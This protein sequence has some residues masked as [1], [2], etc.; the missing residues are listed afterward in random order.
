MRNERC[1]AALVT[2]SLRES[3]SAF[4]AVFA[5][6]DLRRLQLAGAGSVIG[7][8][9]YGIALAVYAYREGGAAAVG[10]LGVVRLLPSALGAPF[11]SQLADRF[12]RQR[13]MLVS[14]LVRLA[15]MG[16]IAAA[17]GLDAPVAVVFGL[18]ALSGLAGTAFRPAQAALLPTLA[19]TPREL[20]AANVAASTI[21]SLGS[22]VGPAL[23]GLLLVVASPAW[24][25]G[26]NALTFVWS[27]LLVAGVRGEGAG[28]RPRRARGSALDEATAG[29]RAIG[30]EPRVRVLVAL[31]GAQTF[32]DGARPVLVV[33]AAFSMLEI[34]ESGVGFLNSALGVGGLLGAVLSVGLVGRA[35][36]GTDFA[37]GL[38]LW[39]G[40]LALVGVWPE[41]AAA[42]FFLAVLGIGNTLVDVAGYTLL[43][44]AAP[45]EVLARV[46]GALDSLLLGTA[47]LG[48]LVAP[49]A[50]ELVGI[51]AAVVGLGGLLPLLAVLAWARLR[52]LDAAG[53]PADVDLLRAVPMLAPLPLATLEQLAGALVRVSAAAGEEIVRAGDGGDR[54]YVIA[55]GEL[56]VDT[57]DGPRALGPG[58]YFGEIALLRDVPR[59]TTVRAVTAA[60][61]LA[62]EREDFLA[63][64]TGNAASAE[65]ADAVVSARLG[66]G[67]RSEL[68]M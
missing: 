2:G 61:L 13:V 53:A 7:N 68:G 50:I 10:L 45:D 30:A 23:G 15:L 34:G 33:T 65:A 24:V 47:V 12:R 46:F 63:A 51:R 28:A 16:A 60:D 43:Q 18:A 55:G 26:F 22:F 3:L 58:D 62:L 40:G 64:V 38:A 39:G 66:A 67:P 11:I 36:L 4:R 42:L 19:R 25:V 49:L 48:A 59:T 9:S 6:R 31:Y 52:A 29:F 35:R 1:D 8:W 32:V 20:T 37:I 44:R 41:A 17:I 56:E 21:D 57:A 5:N 14:D 54:F 27:T